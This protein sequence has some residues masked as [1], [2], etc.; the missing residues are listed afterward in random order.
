[1]VRLKFVIAYTLNPLDATCKNYPSP[2]VQPK[3]L[4]Q[5]TGANVDVA[6]WSIIETHTAMICT[7][8]IA[9]RPL[10]AKYFPALFKSTRSGS[11]SKP[12]ST[13]SWR[14]RIDSKINS[15]I[16]SGHNNGFESASKDNVLSTQEVDERGGIQNATQFGPTESS[17]LSSFNFELVPLSN[18]TDCP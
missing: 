9:I 13:K 1:M 12:L 6:V 4:I 8:L 7:C 17:G 10:L 3:P 2:I 15:R 16:S 14:R 11:S 18:V 5:Q